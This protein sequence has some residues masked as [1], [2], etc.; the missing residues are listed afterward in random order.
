MEL[1]VGK[2]QDLERQVKVLGSAL[3]K[4]RT[5]AEFLADQR[6]V[7][8][9]RYDQCNTI[10][11]GWELKSKPWRR[12]IQMC[13]ATASQRTD[14][15]E[16]LEPHSTVAVWDE[17]RHGGTASH[18]GCCSGGTE[19]LQERV[20]GEGERGGCTLYEGAAQMY[21]ALPGWLASVTEDPVRVTLCWQLWT[22]P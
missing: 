11:A 15:Q 9:V 3:G 12:A 4:A 10:T 1:Q 16:E 21:G 7:T 13:T 18:P 2:V 8:N 14:R 22:T 20:K 19:A 17:V 6:K 5:G